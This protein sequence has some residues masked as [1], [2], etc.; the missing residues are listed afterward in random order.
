MTPS[1]FAIGVVLWGLWA[2]RTG[3]VRMQVLL[4]LFGGTTALTL[5]AVGGATVVVPDF[6]LLFLA[7]SAF[8]ETR[9]T[10]EARFVSR[11]TFWL[12]ATAVWGTLL[13]VFVPRALRGTIE[14]MALAHDDSGLVPLAPVTGNV[15][16]CVYA[17][18]NVIAF[19]SARV[20]LKSPERV[21]TFVDAALTLAFL[22]C[23]A[24][25]LS[26][27][28]LMTNMPSV[29][30]FVRTAYIAHHQRIGAL[31]R[32]HGTFPETSAFSSFSLGLFA[33]SFQLWLGGVVPRRSGS[34]AALLLLCLMF[35]TSG[36]AYGGL[37]G[38]GLALTGSLLAR[39]ASGRIVPRLAW[40]FALLLMAWAT[41]GLLVVFDAGVV[42]SISHFFEDAVFNKMDSASGI[43]RGSWNTQ[44]LQNFVDTW[45]LGVG[46]GTVRTS[47]FAVTLLSNLGVIGTLTYG[48]FLWS[49][50]KI[51]RSAWDGEES[52]VTR[53]G[54][55]AVLALLAAACLS[56]TVFHLGTVVYVFAALASLPAASVWLDARGFA[57]ER[58]VGRVPSAVAARTEVASSSY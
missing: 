45:G 31:P 8:N 48:A 30:D 18:G 50:L 1:L 20:L 55:H 28:E 15:T 12:A 41:A 24:G 46:L 54:R 38:Y 53:A 51:K 14:V 32:L 34:A 40:V 4:L 17:V 26:G 13:A 52:V 6:A 11:G 27:I 10:G 9:T 35:S 22:N 37:A 49:V 2:S 42:S 23:A 57:F 44:G 21:R 16:Q 7:A 19:A 29:L 36:T 33:F 43:E 58:S 56:G 47:S 5:D 25:I 3:V 39:A